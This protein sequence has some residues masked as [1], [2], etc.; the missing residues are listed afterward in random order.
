MIALLLSL[1]AVQAASSPDPRKVT[2]ITEA[3]KQCELDKV[4]VRWEEKA[5]DE[6]ALWVTT[7]AL[8]PGSALDSPLKECFFPWAYER[9]VKV[10]LNLATAS[11]S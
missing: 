6:V 2:K 1:A 9:D 8:T 3:V 11:G 10:E 5:S 4:V 7:D